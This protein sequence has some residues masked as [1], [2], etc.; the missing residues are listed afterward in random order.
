MFGLRTTR[1]F[2]FCQWYQVRE[3]QAPSREFVQLRDEP[4]AMVTRTSSASIRL[5][6]SG[7]YIDQLC[8]NPELAASGSKAGIIR[9]RIS[10]GGRFQATLMRTTATTKTLINV[11]PSGERSKR[12]R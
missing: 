7:A 5:G 3:D 9:R 8:A 6:G 2:S 11:S 12:R 1:S 4:S 10:D